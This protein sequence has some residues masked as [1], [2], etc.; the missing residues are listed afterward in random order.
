MTRTR[1][2]LIFKAGP[3][4]LA[5]RI[6]VQARSRVP[7]KVALAEP[8]PRKAVTGKPAG[9]A[10]N[11]LIAG[12]QGTGEYLTKI[13][14]EKGRVIFD[15]MRRSDPI[16]RSTL[17][18]IELP[19]RRAN[20]DIEPGADDG[21]QDEMCEIMRDNLFNGMTRT[22]DD[23]VRHGLLCL[24]FGFSIL[25]KLWRY[26]G[27]MLEIEKLDPR[28]PMS[29]VKWSEKGPV[30]QDGLGKEYELPFEKILIFSTDKEGDNWEG[31]SILRGS[32][33][34]WVIK[35]KLE[36]IN[37]VK[38][39]RYGVGLPVLTYPKGTTDDVLDEFEDM[40]KN[41]NSG[42][43]S[44]AMIPDGNK[45]E[46]LGVGGQGSGT[47]VLPSIKYCDEAIAKSMLA[48]FINLGSTEHGSRALG[49]SFVDIFLM[50][51]QSMADYM[52]EVFSRFLI[53]EYVNVNWG[54]Q[55][56]YPRMTVSEIKELDAEVIAKLYMAGVLTQDEETENRIRELLHLPQK[57]EEEEEEEPPEQPP[58]GEPATEEPDEVADENEQ[59]AGSVKLRQRERDLT[60]EEQIADLVQIE[61]QLNE[62]YESLLAVLLEIKEKQ[63]DDIIAKA[64]G[65]LTIYKIHPPSKREMYE[66]LMREYKRM[67]RIGRGDAQ[68]EMKRQRPQM[69]FR[70]GEGLELYRMADPPMTWEEYFE[71]MAEEF[72]IASESTA[73]ALKA[74]VAS[75]VTEYRRKGLRGDELRSAVE[76]R[77]GERL[78]DRLWRDA[79][80]IAINR[81]Y[82]AGRL[83]EFAKYEDE[84]DYCY[85]SAILDYNVCAECAPKDGHRHQL[86][87]PE[88]VTPNPECLGNGNC[89]CMTICVM[90]A[91]SAPEE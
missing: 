72:T 57:P 71:L 51:L 16:V 37:A 39:E 46:L 75:A 12:F 10:G 3:I 66:A 9:I 79:A 52:A 58:P 86:G 59:I 7:V 38:H 33:K 73:D 68:K 69:K 34:P 14:G 70:E 65:G 26:N 55:E 64:V 5:R 28:L 47:D 85:Y 2:K 21:S 6:Q 81:G 60:E 1:R 42:E 35:D 45:L 17:R 24:P 80:A 89:R 61:M 8:K 77:V 25:E 91:E 83:M 27:Q 41:I 4:E 29:I 30:Q 15:Q 13:D 54:P 78:S 22:W 76:Q 63:K 18:A 90:K 84:I 20:W 36:K 74:S 23:T 53:E 62:N 88:F 44:Y 31:I 49:I 82:G 50:S 56:K 40:L 19:I 32:Y 43:E 87:D 48:M 11:S 67:A